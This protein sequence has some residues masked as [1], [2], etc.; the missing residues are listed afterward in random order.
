MSVPDENPGRQPD[1]ERA[2]FGKLDHSPG[3]RFRSLMIVMR[4]RLRGAWQ[5]IPVPEGASRFE[6]AVLAA[7]LAA[8]FLCVFG[9]DLVHRF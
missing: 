2:P 1:S 8:C 3:L 5:R 4:H 6:V 7:L 9:Y